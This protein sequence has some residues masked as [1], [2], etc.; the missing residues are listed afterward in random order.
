[1]RKCG[2]DAET[3]LRENNHLRRTSEPTYSAS[4]DLHPERA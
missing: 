3:A 2:T 1:M 4:A